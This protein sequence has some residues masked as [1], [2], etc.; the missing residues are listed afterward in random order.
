MFAGY[1]SPNWTAIMAGATI[2]LLPIMIIFVIFQRYFVITHHQGLPSRDSSG[3]AL[4]P[5]PREQIPYRV[6]DQTCHINCRTKASK[7]VLLQKI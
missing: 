4:S 1:R 7:T 5:L 2:S 3:S 6:L